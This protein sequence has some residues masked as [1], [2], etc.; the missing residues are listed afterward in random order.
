MKE[1]AG[2]TT[3]GSALSLLT[4]AGTGSGIAPEH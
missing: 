4:F 2:F 1:Q 3:K